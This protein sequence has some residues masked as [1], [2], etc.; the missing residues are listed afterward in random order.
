MSHSFKANFHMSGEISYH[1]MHIFVT[2]QI[3]MCGKVKNSHVKIT[4]TIEW[5]FNNLTV[6][7]T[8]EIIVD[9]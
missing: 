5:Y 7:I 9:H 3:L 6:M 1:S 8:T 2:S 4:V